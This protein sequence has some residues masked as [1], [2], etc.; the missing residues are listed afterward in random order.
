M[1]NSYSNILPLGTPRR[2]G[3]SG[4]ST[5]STTLEESGE[6]QPSSL[7]PIRQTS[8]R[9]KLTTDC[10]ECEFK[11]PEPVVKRAKLDTPKYIYQKLFLEGAKSDV[12]IRALGMSWH[13]HKLYLEQCDYFAALFSERWGAEKK[14]V[15]E[16]DVLDSRVNIPGLDNVFASLYQNEIEI[17]LD[18]IG[19]V[20]ASAS[21]INLLV[22][23][24]RCDD[25]MVETMNGSN[26]L[27]YLELAS[28][29]GCQTTREAAMVLLERMFWKY[30]QD[31][32]FLK[33]L[34][35]DTLVEVCA[36]RDLCICE[37]EKDLYHAI[38]RWFYIRSKNELD[39][40][41]SDLSKYFNSQPEHHFYKYHLLLKNV[42]FQHMITSKRTMEKLK[43]D[44]L[45]GADML[46]T[47]MKDLWNT[48]LVNEDKNEVSS[49]FSSEEVTDDFFYSHCR[50]LGRHLEEG[51]KCWRWA[52]Y[53]FGL[54][55]VVRCQFRTV[56]LIRNFSRDHGLFQLSVR[57]LTRIHYRMVILNA[58]GQVLLDSGR[59]MCELA[60][61][62]KE[63]VGSVSTDL[64]NVSIHLFY[65]ASVPGPSADKYWT[66]IESPGPS[67]VKNEV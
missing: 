55:L 4:P 37:G 12:T 61:D 51:N 17:D 16:L 11:T 62:E 47:M 58:S 54:D 21:M 38:R 6:A 23:I 31:P 22:V 15:Y 57:K 43:H 59:K 56:Y 29:Y 8:R 39:C 66:A 53:D 40:P 30:S 36:R 2:N 41:D 52:G 63:I 18:N 1:G 27:E 49:F 14:R 19:G 33:R 50:R 32:A 34:S 26:V 10:S 60:L 3:I 67:E 64:T 25:V 9:R 48:L 20:L 13:L 42:R 24:Q 46:D 44:H 28:A 65:L 7:T 35:Y 45:I 5:S